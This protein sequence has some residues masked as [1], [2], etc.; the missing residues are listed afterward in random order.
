MSFIKVLIKDSTFDQ[1]L[2]VDERYPGSPRYL[3][4]SYPPSNKLWMVHPTSTVNARAARCAMDEIVSFRVSVFD[5][6][7][8]L[9]NVYPYVTGVPTAAR[10][11][12][13]AGGVVIVGHRIARQLFESLPYL[14]FDIA[15][16]PDYLAGVHETL[17]KAISRDGV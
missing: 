13:P 4:N 3:V 7:T 6:S 10:L 9:A 8:D 12:S 1:T 11:P 17:C 16:L 15:S 14:R 5:P 2:Y